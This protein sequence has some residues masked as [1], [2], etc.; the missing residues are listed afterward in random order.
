MGIK[1]SGV[2]SPLGLRSGSTRQLEHQLYHALIKISFSCLIFSIFKRSTG[3]T[4]GVRAVARTGAWPSGT[5][6]STSKQNTFSKG[7]GTPV[8]DPSGL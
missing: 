3:L 1:Q 6:T 8:A 2:N 4:F 7:A 5:Q